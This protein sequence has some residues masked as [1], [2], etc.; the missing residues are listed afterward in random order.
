MPSPATN[1]RLQAL[2]KTQHILFEALGPDGC[3]YDAERLAKLLDWNVE[4][5]GAYLR[6]DAAAV[7]NFG[8]LALRQESL[9]AL[10]R[11]VLHMK[12]AFG[13]KEAAAEWCRTPIRAFDGASPKQLILAQNLQAIHGLLD[14][15][16]SGL[17]L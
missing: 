16:E 14:E 4:D 1:P 9:A 3:K 13:G 17:S 7:K 8:S 6:M 5:M 11:L 12:R 10:A 15:M 2:P